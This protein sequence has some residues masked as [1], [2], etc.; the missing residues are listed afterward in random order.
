MLIH[1]NLTNVIKLLA[2]NELV[3]HQRSHNEERPFKCDFIFHK[4]KK[5]ITRGAAAKAATEDKG[6]FYETLVPYQ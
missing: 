2:K 4:K 1:S 5:F 6:I 3:K